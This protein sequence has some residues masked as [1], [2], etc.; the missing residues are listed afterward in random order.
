M[1][2]NTIFYKGK[3]PSKKYWE[4]EIIPEKYKDTIEEYNVLDTV[5]DC[6]LLYKFS[7]S[8]KEAT[9]LDTKYFILLRYQR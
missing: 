8:I 2:R 4:G 7:K 1:T 3:T 6:I 9:G 5:S